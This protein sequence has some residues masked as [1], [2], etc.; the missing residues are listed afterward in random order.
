MNGPV[1]GGRRVAYAVAGFALVAALL[2]LVI[3]QVWIHQRVD[4]PGYVKIATPN[5]RSVWRIEGSGLTHRDAHGYRVGY[6]ED[7]ARPRVLVL[8]DSF[9]EALEVND[10]EV[11][12]AV[13]QRK[14]ES[15]GVNLSLVNGGTAGRSAADYVAFVARHRELVKPAWTVIVLRD[16]D[17][18]E[19]SVRDGKTRFVRDAGGKLTVLVDEPRSAGELRDALWGN[20]SIFVR[21][22]A[23]RI[24]KFAE[25]AAEEPPLFFAADHE[26]KMPAATDYRVY[27]VEEALDLVKTAHEGRVT[28]ISLPYLA[29]QPPQVLDSEVR[30][31]MLAHCAK[32]GLSCLE[33]IDPFLALARDY[34]SPFGFLNSQFNFGH[35][36]P[37]GHAALAET[38]A[39]ELAR[40]RRDAV[41]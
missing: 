11:F 25:A 17:L 29:I 8:G 36:N 16:D 12:T 4:I 38:L 23:Y 34:R 3:R 30:R 20:P 10:D 7:P 35:M 6:A 18:A 40:L 37:A 13:A 32:I 28:I 31:R 41:F 1:T 24:N 19:D 21:Y 2:E 26:G 15:S 39:D 5:T 9:T 33:P 14:L 22:T 27:P